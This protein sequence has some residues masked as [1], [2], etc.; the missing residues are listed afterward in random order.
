MGFNCATLVQIEQSLF[1]WLKTQ[2][3][4]IALAIQSQP[5]QTAQSANQKSK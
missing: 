5:P 2:I 4:V 1:E 3:K